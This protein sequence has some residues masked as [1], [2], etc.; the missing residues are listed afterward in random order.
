MDV[1]QRA[2]N[3]VVPS[4]FGTEMA[5]IFDGL[6][7]ERQ[8]VFVFWFD[9]VKQ[10]VDVAAEDLEREEAAEAGATRKGAER[11]RE[12]GELE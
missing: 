2:L 11:E 1:T 6:D 8:D 10:A 7:L 9:L 4:C 3:S 5:T 12:R